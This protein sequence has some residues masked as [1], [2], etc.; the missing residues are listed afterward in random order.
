MLRM[1]HPSKQG[2]KNRKK[3]SSLMSAPGITSKRNQMKGIRAEWD[4]GCIE[5]L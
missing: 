3:N 5:K 1:R 4:G 2:E